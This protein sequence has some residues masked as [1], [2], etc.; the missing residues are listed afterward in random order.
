M[1]EWHEG[2]STP[3]QQGQ[4]P[5]AQPPLQVPPPPPGY[6]PPGYSPPAY[7]PQYPQH[8]YY[9]QYP[10]IRRVSHHSH[11]PRAD[12]W[13]IGSGGTLAPCTGATCRACC[14]W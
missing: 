13:E 4:R 12:H 7:S 10:S 11:S 2:P 5:D 3:G 9:Q 1:S 8:P 14:S 6:P